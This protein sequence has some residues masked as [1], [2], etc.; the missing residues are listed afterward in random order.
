MGQKMIDD[1]YGDFPYLAE[2]VIAEPGCFEC[3]RF[4]V[5][6]W[7]EE[8]RFLY[9]LEGSVEIQML[10]GA[11]SLA[12]GQG[13][14]INQNVIH[15]VKGMEG[16]HYGSF[17]VPV[18]LLEF[19][20][21]SPVRELVERLAGEPLLPVYVFHGGQRWHEQALDCLRRLCLMESEKSA[22]YPYEVL[23]Q[24]VSLWLAMQ[25]NIV[26]SAGKRKSVSAVRMQKFLYFIG[27]HYREDVLLEELAASAG[28]S[29]SECLRCFKRSL[30]T[31][32]YKYLMDYRIS[33]AADLLWNTD[34]QIG[35]IAVLAGFDKASYFGKCFRERIGCTPKEFR[36]RRVSGNAEKNRRKACKKV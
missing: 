4:Q 27:Q 13:I 3:G 20:G 10:N 14:F 28:V 36:R 11:V 22:L 6:R 25:K 2:L 5:M 8:L 24:L 9:V 1:H 17:F 30:N 35:E 12:A 16:C 7:Y 32:P 18:Y 31:T 15:L 19:Y 21:G 26:F 23:V 34:R 29:K 33:V